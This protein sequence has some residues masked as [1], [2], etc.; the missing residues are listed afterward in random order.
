MLKQKRGTIINVSSGLGVRGMRNCSAYSASKFGLNG[1][2]QSVADEMLQT[3]LKFY[4]I[5]PGAVAT[6]LHLDIHPW[7]NPETMMTPEY[8]GEKIFTVAYGKEPSGTSIEIY[9]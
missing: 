9:E 2:T 7:E 5:L 3:P 4:T 1:L 6:K 8:I